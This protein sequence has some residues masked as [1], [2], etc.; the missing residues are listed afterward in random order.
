MEALSTVYTFF[1]GKP[2]IKI[3]NSTYND[4]WA[5]VEAER[6]YLSEIE[7]KIAA[8]VKGVDVS[9]TPKAKFEWMT[10]NT[11]YSRIASEEWLHFD[12]PQGGMEC[13]VSVVDSDGKVFGTAKCFRATNGT[14]FNVVVCDDYVMRQGFKNK[15]F[16]CSEGRKE[17]YGPVVCYGCGKHEC[18]SPE[19][20]GS[21]GWCGIGGKRG[22]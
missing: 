6:K 13:Y 7:A 12:V 4:I 15:T 16:R 11:G 18:K 1:A 20:E 19:T 21:D 22:L 14:Y 2:Q 5:R 10:Q 9:L 17:Y 3:A 8:N